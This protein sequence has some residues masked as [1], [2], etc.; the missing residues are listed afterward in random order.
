MVVSM[1]NVRIRLTF[2]S[3]SARGANELLRIVSRCN[4][5]KTAWCRRISFHVVK[6]ELLFVDRPVHPR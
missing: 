2:G 3:S 5:K 1:E 4:N 6:I